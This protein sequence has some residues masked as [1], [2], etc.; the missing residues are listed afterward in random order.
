MAG[1]SFFS[2]Y[3]GENRGNEG[4]LWARTTVVDGVDIPCK[5]CGDFLARGHSKCLKTDDMTAGW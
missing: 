4:V 5:V 3:W 2:I 1:G